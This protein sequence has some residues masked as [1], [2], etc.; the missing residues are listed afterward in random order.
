MEQ[1]GTG[2][3]RRAGRT[4]ST[5]PLQPGTD[6]PRPSPGSRITRVVG[7]GLVVFGLLAVAFVPFQL[8]GT[9]LYQYR[10]QSALRNQ[11]LGELRAPLTASPPGR[12]GSGSA[13]TGAAAELGTPTAAPAVGQPVAL[14]TIPTIG[15]SQVVVQGVDT[16]RLRE[17]PGHYPGTPLPGQPGNAAVAG[18]RTTYGAPFSH[19]DALRPGDFVYFRTVQGLFRY[20]VLRTLVVSPSDVAVLDRAPSMSTVTLTT[21][22]PRYSAA[23]R[24]VVVAA[25]SGDSADGTPV[26]LPPPPATGAADP[27]YA[28]LGDL[29]GAGGGVLLVVDWLLV[30]LAAVV[31][32]RIVWVRTPRRRRWMVTTTG[33]LVTM[34]ALFLC[35]SAVSLALPASF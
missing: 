23:Q 24:L 32:T 4:L 16:A 13:P 18:H 22:N 5:S 17:G 8:W 7:L 19:L 6:P 3:R 35:F 31:A 2:L 34:A 15:V 29:G 25:F 9:A 11:L 14:L 10:A 30:A 20:T 28:P 33:S 12:P 27:G 26:Q 1:P 21:C